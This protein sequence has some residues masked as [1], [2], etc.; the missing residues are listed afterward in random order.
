MM[1]QVMVKHIFKLAECG[2]R[3]E[4]KLGDSAFYFFTANYKA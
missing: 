4:I 3:D 2:E 1:S